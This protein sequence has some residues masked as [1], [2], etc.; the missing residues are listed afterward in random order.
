MIVEPRNASALAKAIFEFFDEN[1]EDAFIEGIKKREYK[2]SWDR[3]REA[4]EED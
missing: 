3:M 1:R 2:F 4:L